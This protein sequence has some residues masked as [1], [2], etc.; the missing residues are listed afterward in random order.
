MIEIYE[1]LIRKIPEGSSLELCY[2]QHGEYLRLYLGKTE[3][4]LLVK[5]EDAYRIF[6]EQEQ[7]YEDVREAKDNDRVVLLLSG[8][9]LNA[10]MERERKEAKEE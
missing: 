7:L 3:V 5:E 6:S 10:M 2:N 1:E 4:F 8:L 9:I